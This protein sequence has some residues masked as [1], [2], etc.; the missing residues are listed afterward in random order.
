VEDENANWQKTSI[1]IFDL[2][3]KVDIEFYKYTLD[4]K[5]KLTY[6]SL[7][8]NPVVIGDKVYFDDVVT[9]D[10]NDIYK[11]QLLTYDIRRQ[12]I[13]KAYDQ[14]KIPMEYKGKLAWLSMSADKKN[15]I[16]CSN[17]VKEIGIVKS[18]TRLGTVYS[19]CRDVIV[20]NDFLSK[21]LFDRIMNNF[22]SGNKKSVNFKDTTNDPSISSYG[23]KLYIGKQVIPI[24]VVENG[25]ATNVV[26]NGSII[27]WYGSSI[28]APMF[29]DLIKDK[30]IY[31]DNLKV[32]K[33]SGYGIT[34]CNNY[35]ILR[36]AEDTEGAAEQTLLWSLNEA[37]E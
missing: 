37:S 25:F 7:F 9:K 3:T 14:A 20:T 34:L 11:I 29:Y 6:T 5:T 32:S 30:I 28:G 24:M 15:S 33:F 27:G 21:T 8:N 16:F 36:Y 26:T 12:K 22:K 10:A 4:P 35:V 17:A 1:H 2:Q 23:I 13:S 19:S 18:A 31:I